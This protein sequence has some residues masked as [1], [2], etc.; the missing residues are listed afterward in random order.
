MSSMY[1]DALV[2][3]IS[4]N[5]AI[6]QYVIKN[7]ARARCTPRG[8]K[9]RPRT[10]TAA[11]CADHHPEKPLI[12]VGVD[13]VAVDRQAAEL[14]V[15]QAEAED[16]L[17]LVPRVGEYRTPEVGPAAEAGELVGSS[18]RAS[19]AMIGPENASTAIA[20]HRAR[21]EKLPA[22]PRLVL[23]IRLSAATSMP[24]ST[25][26]SAVLVWVRIRITPDATTA[27][28]AGPP[29]MQPQNQSTATRPRVIAA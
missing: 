8:L 29:R 27:N 18:P 24:A 22:Y 13:P 3:P 11:W 20:T 10:G 12:L 19:Q 15:R 14:C 21:G 2:N 7:R 17:E 25:P 6:R 26:T 16:L 28:R 23:T 1:G 5:E 4:V 9:K